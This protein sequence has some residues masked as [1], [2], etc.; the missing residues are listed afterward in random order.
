MFAD[1]EL[2]FL[3]YRGRIEGEEGIGLKRSREWPGVSLV[4]CTNRP[5]FFDNLLANFRRQRYPRKEL[6]IVL[7]NDRMNVEEYRR[8]TQGMS[9]VAVY[10]VPERISLGQSLN[11][12]I[13]KT[14]YPL[15]AKFDD[16]DYYS[17]DYLQEQVGALLRTGSDI[18]GKH[19]CLVYLEGARQLL[20]RSPQE[21]NKQVEFVQG[22]TILF[23]RSVLRQVWFPD[24]SVGEDVG[25]L[26]ACRT[27]GFKT[28]A[29][30]PYRYVY[31]RRKNKQSHTWRAN[32]DFYRNGSIPLAVTD[33]YRGVAAFRG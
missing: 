29:T 2:S 16:D 11:C 20:I 18:V 28:Y 23:R 4:V 24:K 32:D 14:R 33:D 25:F 30:S 6:V 7:N 21:K 1:T 19:A 31:I 26:T 22:G 9:Q 13:Q 17:P 12:G 3:S 5:V 10:Q 27:K 15:I 8:R